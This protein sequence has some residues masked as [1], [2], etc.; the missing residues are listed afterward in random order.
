MASEWNL[1]EVLDECL[2]IIAIIETLSDH[3]QLG[4]MAD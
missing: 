3:L 1:T 4:T 2:I